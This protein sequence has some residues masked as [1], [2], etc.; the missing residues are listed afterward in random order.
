MNPKFST[1]LLLLIG[2]LLSFQ[3]VEGVKF[4]KFSLI[5]PK[6]AALKCHSV[7]D[8]AIE[9]VTC[10]KDDVCLN[11]A[12]Q[13]NDPQTSLLI[14]SKLKNKHLFFT[15]KQV[16]VFYPAGCGKCARDDLVNK[17]CTQ[18]SS[19]LCNDAGK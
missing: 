12:T 6:L 9:E 13:Y 8:D 2:V 4:P 1:T 19:D 16:T 18:C 14:T 15:D 7:F 11:E 17:K 10:S 3:T 5:Y